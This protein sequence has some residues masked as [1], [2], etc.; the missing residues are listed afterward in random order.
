MHSFA[1]V[2]L[3]IG[4]RELGEGF[5]MEW[6]SVLTVCVAK[7]ATGRGKGREERYETQRPEQN[8]DRLALKD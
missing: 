1:A 8:P 4:I 2:C 7:R 5:R 3:S 6:G